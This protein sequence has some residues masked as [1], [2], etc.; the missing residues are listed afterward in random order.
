[1]SLKHPIYLK[2]S[3]GI[4][5]VTWYWK[6]H[7]FNV[8]FEFCSFEVT[9]LLVPIFTACN[10]A[11]VFKCFAAAQSGHKLENARVLNFS[12]HVTCQ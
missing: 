8:L 3:P 5:R 2:G 12:L 10:G 4:M 11:V 9:T 7:R 6:I 1:M